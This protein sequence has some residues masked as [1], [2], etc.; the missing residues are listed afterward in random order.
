M[1]AR[2]NTLLDE[3]PILFLDHVTALCQCINA[4][5]HKNDYRYDSSWQSFKFRFSFV[6]QGNWLSI[7]VLS[8]NE[9]AHRLHFRGKKL[10]K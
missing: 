1:V 10:P 9:V 7:L 6:M 4:N 3:L 2:D 5:H 8:S